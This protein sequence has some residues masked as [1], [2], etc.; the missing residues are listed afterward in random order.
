MRGERSLSRNRIVPGIFHT[1]VVFVIYDQLV[2]VPVAIIVGVHKPDRLVASEGRSNRWS[3][4]ENDRVG[5]SI[6]PAVAAVIYDNFSRPICSIPN[7]IRL[8]TICDD[9][10][11]H[12][13][14]GVLAITVGV[15][16]DQF[17]EPPRSSL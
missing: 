2:L 1:V 9:R 4:S 12:R 7:S 8:G 15:I 5:R 3:G 11:R 10:F 16:Q 17:A 13:R 14:V 6:S